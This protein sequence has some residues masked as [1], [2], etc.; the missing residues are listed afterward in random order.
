MFL[1]EC[2]NDDLRS[3][4]DILVYDNNGKIRISENL[5]NTDN[6]LSCYPQNMNGMYEDL[7]TEL[8]CFGGNS[9]ANAFR[10]GQGPSYK[11]V[12]SDVCKR[13]KVNVSKSD[14][15][16]NM[17]Q[18]LLIAISSKAIGYLSEAEARAIM[19]DCQIKSN[20]RTKAGLAA[21][22]VVL[23]STNKRLFV[24]LICII[25][26]SMCSLLIGR[27]LMI[28]GAN[29]LSRGL[30]V[31]TGPL[32]W[33]ALGGWTIYDLTNPAY[34]VTIPAVILV[35]YMRVKYQASLISNVA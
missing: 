26:R 19:E 12:L 8:L 33:L 10:H 9:I 6:Y 16:E 29:V 3:L 4:C 1:R 2:D 13:M 14:S 27:E 7:A 15:V 21:A 35:A 24:N 32:G 28:V 5:T 30:C 31:I 18:N 23:R 34:R 11:T 17:E 22:L 25:M 20:N